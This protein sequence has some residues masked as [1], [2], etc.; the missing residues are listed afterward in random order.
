VKP[1]GEIADGDADALE[2]L[3]KSLNDGGRLFSGV[4]LN[5]PGGSLLEA[6]KLAELI[7][8]AKISTIVAI[9]SKCASACFVAFAAG[10]EKFVSYSGFVGVHGASD[11]LD[12]ETVESGAATVSMARI[13]KE[14]GVPASIIGKMVV[15]PPEELVWLTPDDL[16]SMGAVLTGRPAHGPTDEGVGPQ[17]PVPLPLDP[18]GNASPTE[19]PSG[20]SAMYRKAFDAAKR[21]NY[22]QAM[23]IWLFLA[24]QGDGPSQ[25]DVGQMYHAGRGIPQNFVE[26]ARWYRRAAEQGIPHAQLNWVWLTLSAVASLRTSSPRTRGSILRQQ[27]SRRRRNALKRPKLGISLRPE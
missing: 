25:Y 20:S 5:S 24:E 2:A 23:R 13:V 12:H 8:R 9:G 26:A 21:G 15:T 10:T 17:R 16:R 3:I 18:S 1:N 27:D 14:L 7:R 19:S 6:V 4:R 11:K 22:I